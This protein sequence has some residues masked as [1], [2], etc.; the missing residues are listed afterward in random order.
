MKA[1]G[2]WPVSWFLRGGW[3]AVSCPGARGRSCVPP[4]L[5]PG[6]A[7]LRGPAETR[8]L[9]SCRRRRRTPAR[10][11]LWRTRRPASVFLWVPL[12]RVG[13]ALGPLLVGW[14]VRRRQV[15][16]HGA[17]PGLCKW[18]RVP[19]LC[20]RICSLKGPHVRVTPEEPER[21][22]GAES[23]FACARKP[24][25]VTRCSVFRTC[26][27]VADCPR[28]AGPQLS[29]AKHEARRS[30]APGSVKRLWP[31]WTIGRR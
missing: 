18:A 15:W 28:S 3:Q 16:L 1:A 11:S 22:N 30:P 2:V 5:P 29:C 17:S 26:S 21:R 23:L 20:G 25:A 4:V 9:K 6:P 10:R 7:S 24:L 13:L 31:A 12:V 14:I 27:G 19:G 8:W